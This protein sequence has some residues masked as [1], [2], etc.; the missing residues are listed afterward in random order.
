MVA[1]ACGGRS[2]IQFC[3]NLYNTMHIYNLRK[4]QFGIMLEWRE[5]TTMKTDNPIEEI[6]ENAGMTPFDF[7]AEFYEWLNASP[8]SYK[9]A[10]ELCAF[11]AKQHSPLPWQEESVVSFF[12][13]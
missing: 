11:L 9:D 5:D 7:L 13:V 3:A 12:E 8:I 10:I 4:S 2:A 1:P 6:C